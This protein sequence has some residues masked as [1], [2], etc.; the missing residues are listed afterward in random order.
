VA[1]ETC[2]SLSNQNISHINNSTNLIKLTSRGTPNANPFITIGFDWV[3]FGDL[4]SFEI[5][6]L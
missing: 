1:R 6:A 5:N 4:H 2:D 3:K